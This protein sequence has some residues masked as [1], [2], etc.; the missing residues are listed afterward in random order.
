MA[1]GLSLQKWEGKASAKVFF[2]LGGLVLTITIMAVELLRSDA[3]NGW[4]FGISLMCSIIYF[5]FFLIGT[6]P[7][8]TRMVV[9][10][11]G[12]TPNRNIHPKHAAVFFVILLIFAT[13]GF[14]FRYVAP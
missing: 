9:L 2:C 12:P 10:N 3:S 5:I 6:A 1:E 11:G 8:G 13:I 14:G 7:K 4:V